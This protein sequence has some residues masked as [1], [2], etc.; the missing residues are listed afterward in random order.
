MIKTGQWNV[1]MFVSCQVTGILLVITTEIIDMK[2]K[3]E[4]FSF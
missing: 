3:S 1:D 2:K 4:K